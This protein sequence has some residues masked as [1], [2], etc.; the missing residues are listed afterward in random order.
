MFWLY[1]GWRHDLNHLRRR[2]PVPGEFPFFRTSPCDSGVSPWSLANFGCRAQRDFKP[3]LV[4]DAFNSAQRPPL[5][6]KS[7]DSRIKRY[8][9]TMSKKLRKGRLRLKSTWLGIQNRMFVQKWV[10]STSLQK[11]STFTQNLIPSLIWSP[12]NGA[13]WLLLR[14]SASESRAAHEIFGTAGC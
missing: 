7:H 9:Q 13:G 12:G 3:L 4:G 10:S 2:A 14:W 11:I 1:E 5:R 6:V 8:A